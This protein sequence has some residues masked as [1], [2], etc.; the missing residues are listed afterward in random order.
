MDDLMERHLFLWKIGCVAKWMAG[1]IGNKSMAE[2][3]DG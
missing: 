2:I 1:W 3:M